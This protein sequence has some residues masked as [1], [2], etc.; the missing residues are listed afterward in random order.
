MVIV[1]D[2]SERYEDIVGF[3]KRIIQERSVNVYSNVRNLLNVGFQNIIY[4]QRF[5]CKTNQSKKA[6]A[7]SSSIQ[8]LGKISL[9]WTFHPTSALSGSVTVLILFKLSLPH[10]WPTRLVMISSAAV[11]PGDITVYSLPFQELGSRM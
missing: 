1:N 2:Q 3:L 11:L 5:A 9:V 4:F 8:L 6:Y 10:K 7:F